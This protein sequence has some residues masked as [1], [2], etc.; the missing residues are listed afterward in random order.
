MQEVFGRLVEWRTDKEARVH[1]RSL[2][3]SFIRTRA[4]LKVQTE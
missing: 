1:T 2:G 4:K 3:L